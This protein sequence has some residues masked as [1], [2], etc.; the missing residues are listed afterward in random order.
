MDNDQITPPF[1]SPGTSGL[2]GAQTPV[3]STP[4]ISPDDEDEGLALGEIIAV[5]IDYRWLIAA[6]SLAALVLS[7][8]W[9]F[10]A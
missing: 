4:Q 7:L 10:V 5:L 6:I 8:A 2:T 9:L 1:N 3:R